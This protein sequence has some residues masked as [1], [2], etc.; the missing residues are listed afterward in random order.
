MDAV[1]TWDDSVVEGRIVEHEAGT[2]LVS[3]LRNGVLA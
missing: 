1:A 3:R 2:H